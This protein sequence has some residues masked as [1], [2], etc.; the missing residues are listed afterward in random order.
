MDTKTALNTACDVAFEQLSEGDTVALPRELFVTL[1]AAAHAALDLIEQTVL[2]NEDTD[3]H[4]MANDAM[5]IIHDRTQ[6]LHRS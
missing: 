4:A 5:R 1:V 2:P 3:I 6:D